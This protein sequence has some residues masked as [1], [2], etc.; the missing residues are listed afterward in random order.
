MASTFK[1]R[2]KGKEIKRG[3][4]FHFDGTFNYTVMIDCKLDGV[5]QINFFTWSGTAPGQSA[6]I[7]V[8]DGETSFSLRG[9]YNRIDDTTV[10]GKFDFSPASGEIPLETFKD[11]IV[12][13]IV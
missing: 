12:T 9:T 1:I 6:E 7:Q 5:W 3:I 11:V 8:F 10:K 4:R 13:P 2:Q